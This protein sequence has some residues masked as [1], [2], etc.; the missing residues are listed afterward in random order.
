M[1]PYDLRVYAAMSTWS[2]GAGNSSKKRFTPPASS[3]SKAAL[4]RADSSRA[5]C[6]SRSGLRPV[7]S[8]FLPRRMWVG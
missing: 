7:W 3:A 2:I 4:L 1:G 6:S 8:C 5:A